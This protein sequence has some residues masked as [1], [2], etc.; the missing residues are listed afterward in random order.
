M[1]DTEQCLAVV[2]LESCNP[3]TLAL[4]VSLFIGD[5]ML[6]GDT[7]PRRRAP[8]VSTAISNLP[9]VFLIAGQNLPESQVVPVTLL[10]GIIR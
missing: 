2:S 3:G 10:M 8:A 7:M 9:L 4:T 1:L 6:V 5:W